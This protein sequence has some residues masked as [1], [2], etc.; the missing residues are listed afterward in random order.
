MESPT[1]ALEWRIG[2]LERMIGNRS[3]D[4]AAS[5]VSVIAAMALAARNVKAVVDPTG[6]HLQMLR[7]AQSLRRLAGGIDGAAMA[8]A[9]RGGLGDARP[10]LDA[11]AQSLD[12]LGALE[13]VLDGEWR[14]CGVLGA[15]ALEDVRQLQMK[16]DAVERQIEEETR[17]VDSVLVM[18][19]T[20]VERMNLR[21]DNLVAMVLELEET[22][23]IRPNES[24][25]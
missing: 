4:D 21:F 9:A 20:A 12:E 14:T 16:F 19:N 24:D 10:R 18:Y 2:E 3:P 13:G 8:V 17:A 6:I 15:E 7:R 1:A 5:P 25:V 23:G 11:L 22:R